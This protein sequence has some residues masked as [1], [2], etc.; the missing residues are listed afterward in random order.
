MPH[1]ALVSGM[2]Q[3][4]RQQPGRN[5]RWRR[6]SEGEDKKAV[7]EKQHLGRNGSGGEGL[8][9]E[10]EGKKVG[11]KELGW[12]AEKRGATAMV[13]CTPVIPNAKTGPVVG[14]TI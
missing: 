11:V 9:R 12:E 2:N 1:P 6:N 8:G 3:R 13:M 5:G 10:G 14:T 7:V 4:W